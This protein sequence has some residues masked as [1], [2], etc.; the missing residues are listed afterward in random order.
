MT[1]S[2]ID[3]VMNHGARERLLVVT[4][5]P[6]DRGEQ[7]CAQCSTSTTSDMRL[8]LS[9]LCCCASID[10]KEVHDKSWCDTQQEADYTIFLT[11]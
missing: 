8:P 11:F 7:A 2:H 10:R 5:N 6:S 1:S 4:A 9:Q 3:Y